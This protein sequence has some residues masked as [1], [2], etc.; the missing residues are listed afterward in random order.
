M[1]RFGYT[2][3]SGVDIPALI[4]M[5]DGGGSG[6]SGNRFEGAGILSLLANA[7]ASPYGSRRP[8]PG[9]VES[10]QAADNVMYG[11]QEP[12]E[13]PA[14][15]VDEGPMPRAATEEDVA[16]LRQIGGPEYF[17]LQPGDLLSITEV[18]M[19]E[20]ARSM[21]APT[22]TQPPAPTAMPSPVAPMTVAPQLGFDP[23]SA[24]MGLGLN[25]PL[26]LDMFLTAP[27]TAPTMPFGDPGPAIPGPAGVPQTLEE[28]QRLRTNPQSPNFTFDAFGGP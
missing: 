10:E 7:V 25:A 4:D 19:I 23:L 8:R 14:P 28:I 21:P 27:R 26:G 9:Y 24:E 18:Q 11:I 20:E 13:A 1:D 3:Q 22:P 15:S 17:D 12:D 2:T 5:I 16:I 6:Q